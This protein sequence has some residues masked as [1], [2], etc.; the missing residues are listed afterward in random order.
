MNSYNALCF[1]TA[2]QSKNYWL[3]VSMR[4]WPSWSRL[5][6]YPS[7]VPCTVFVVHMNKKNKDWLTVLRVSLADWLSS[8]NSHTMGQ[9]S[10][11]FFLLGFLVLSSIS[12][13]QAESPYRYYTWRLSYAWIYPGNFGPQRVGYITHTLKHDLLELF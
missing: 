2:I 3:L 11:L 13:I 10:F 5:R 9:S 4:S 7:L 8:S 6:Y 12:G 1:V